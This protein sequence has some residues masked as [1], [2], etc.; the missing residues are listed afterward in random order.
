MM[1]V[2]FLVVASFSLPTV[3][4]IEATVF[5]VVMAVFVVIMASSMSCAKV[6]AGTVVVAT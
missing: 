2:A 5:A 1:D 4:E 6:I 3:A